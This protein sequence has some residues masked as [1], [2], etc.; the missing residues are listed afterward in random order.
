VWDD[1][2]GRHHESVSEILDTTV[3]D[4]PRAYKAWST[5][6]PSWRHDV[7]ARGALLARTEHDPRP[8]TPLRRSGPPRA[9]RGGRRSGYS[10]GAGGSA[11]G[12]HGCAR[13][14]QILL[15][16][17][18]LSDVSFERARGEILGIIGRTV[19]ARPRSSMSS[20]ASCWL[21]M[22]KSTGSANPPRTPAA[23]DLPARHRPHLP[24]DAPLSHLTVLENVHGS[25]PLPTAH[26]PI[27]RA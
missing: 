23:R 19:R 1:H 24:G 26:H 12:A 17:Q 14:L 10:G 3:G 13:D 25:A 7:R 9:D 18:A 5:A 27:A 11:I 2:R 8:D 22:A 4:R 15:G 16:L 20:T 21:S 6:P